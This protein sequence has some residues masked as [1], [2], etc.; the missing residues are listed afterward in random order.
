MDAAFRTTIFDIAQ[1][2]SHVS[3]AHN[4]SEG[5][6][7]RV[8]VTIDKVPD[9]LLL[10]VFTF[11]RHSELGKVARVCRKWRLLA[12]DSRLW[13]KVSL[14]PEFSGL[15]VYSPE[16]LQALIGIRFGST[17]RY[18]EIPSDLITAPVLHE[19]AN[20][21][22]AL[23]YMTLDFSNAMQLHDFNDLNA[24][25]C[26]LR[27]LCICLSEVIFLEGFM[28]R[29]YSCLSSLEVLHLIGTFELSSESEEDIYEVINISKIKAHT[30]NL[31]VVN[32]YGIT[33]LDDSHIELLASNCI[34]IECLALNFCLRVKGSSFKNLIQRCKK[35]K[36][37]LLHHAGVEDDHMMSVPWETS[38]IHELDLTSTELSAQCLENI[39][40]RMPGFT[41]LA[42]G[43]CEFFND[44]ILEKLMELGKFNRLQAL[45]ISHTHALSENAIYQFIQTHGQNLRGLMLA[46]KPKLTENFWL[47]AIPYLKNIKICVLGTANGWFLKIA[48]RVHVDQIVEAFAQHC[49]RL[50][51]CEIQWD[52]DTI[53][54][55]DKSNKFIDH[56]R[57]RCPGLKSFALSDGEYY[58][59]V[60]SNFERA[61][62]VKVVRTCTNYTTS[63][64]GLLT[65]YNDL[66]FN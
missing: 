8:S 61:D 35:L 38:A 5:Y 12:Y 22:P 50:V 16:V 19:L 17:L 2:A 65:N 58:E 53:R 45:D 18:I 23:R 46:G 60:K 7:N 25:P 63:I 6:F 64:V 21:C 34:H 43:Y 11:L 52:P 29:I 55:S 28:R 54:F 3:T 51:R 42:L 40:L 66:L 56:I 26:N 39:L 9:K 10:H 13:T 44:K 57:L 24:F 37:L 48:S 20:K 49:P 41:Y 27:S 59:M 1:D 4:E 30:P 14:R 31:K 33:F 15:H 47:N 36:S 62:R 32:L